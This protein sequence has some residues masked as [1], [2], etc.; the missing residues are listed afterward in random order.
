MIEMR[1]A[2][3]LESAT[4]QDGWQRRLESWYGRYDVSAA[5]ASKQVEQKLA[6]NLGASAASTYALTADGTVAGLLAVGIVKQGGQPMAMISD[7]WVAE[8]HRRRGYAS[9]ALRWALSW[10]QARGAASLWAITD[11]AEPA[12]AALFA[13]YTLRAQ[14]MIKRL[15]SPGP[16]PDGLAGRPMTQD[17]FTAWRAESVRGYAADISGSGTLPA[18][19]AAVRAAAEF[20]QLLPAGLSTADHTFLCLDAGG[21]M[22]ATNWICHR[23]WPGVSWVYGVEV[24]EQHRGKGYGRAAMVIGEQATLDAGDTHLALNVFGHN[25]VAISLYDGMGYQAIEKA[26]SI[27]L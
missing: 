14:Q 22:V 3:G 7:L 16:L 15:G 8:P 6:F 17:E 25:T 10:A 27:D 12:H 21:E 9:A 18:A 11:P 24:S 23:R 4:W 1:E 2:S 26:R 19:E 20:D 13:G 5:W